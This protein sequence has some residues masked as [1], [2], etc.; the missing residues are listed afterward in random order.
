[1]AGSRNYKFARMKKYLKDG[2]LGMPVED[3]L[4]YIN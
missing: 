1:M 2:P 3:Y 4:D